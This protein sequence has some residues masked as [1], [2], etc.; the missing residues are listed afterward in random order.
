MRL[1]AIGGSAGSF[2]VVQH[3]LRSLPSSYMCPI[4]LCLHRPKD[5]RSGFKKALSIR[6]TL[7][8]VEPS[9]KDPIVP[10]HVYLAPSNYHLYVEL[11]HR[12]ALSTEDMVNHSRPSIDLLFCSVARVYRERAVGIILSG[13]NRDG[14]LGLLRLHRNGGYAIAQRPEDCAVSTMVEAAVEQGAVDA[15]LSVDGIV[16]YIKSIA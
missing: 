10:G 4:L 7:P 8:L 15:T 16:E 3:I 9:D 5:V 1:I 14:A 11:G 2:H 6:A 13:A 12:F